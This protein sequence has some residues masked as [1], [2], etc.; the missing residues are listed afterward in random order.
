MHSEKQVK[1]AVT[2][3]GR[4]FNDI[5]LFDMSLLEMALKINLK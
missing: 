3:C 2:S 1:W 4:C 5:T